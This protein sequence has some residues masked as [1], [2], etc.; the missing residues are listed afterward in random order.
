MVFSYILY[1]YPDPKITFGYRNMIRTFGYPKPD[2][3]PT[4][5]VTEPFLTGYLPKISSTRNVYEVSGSDEIETAVSVFLYNKVVKIEGL[6]RNCWNAVRRKN[7]FRSTFIW[8]N[9]HKKNS[10]S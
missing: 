2:D 8:H 1:E 6:R 5:N 9:S 10:V 7:D 3:I 4:I